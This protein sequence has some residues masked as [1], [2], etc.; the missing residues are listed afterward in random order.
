[1]LVLIWGTTWSAIRVGLEGIPPLSGVAIRFAIAGLVLAAY[2]RLTGAPWG[3]SSPRVRWLWLS[4]S[5]LCFSAAY[6]ITYWAE[7]W[8]PSGLASVL[9]GTYTLFVVGF[10]QLL[11]K[12]EPLRP[13]VAFGTLLGFV[14]VAVIFSEDFE[15]LGGAEVLFPALVLL[16]APAASALDSVLVKRS[17]GDLHPVTLNAASMLL[18]APT[19]GLVALVTERERVWHL[20]AAPVLATIYLALFGSALAFT[21][22]FWLLRHTSATKLS[23][24]AYAIPV[25][26]VT[27]GALA[28]GEPITARV[29]VGGLLVLGGVAA[30]VR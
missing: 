30:T 22:F 18:T 11:L 20:T 10:A 13:V 16:L 12:S 29:V 9:F 4:H 5:V 17:G 19:V 23:T 1:L 21:L 25:V 15:R 27:I 7:Q 8:V 6:G 3:W 28:L 2:A 14:G 26:A 24:I